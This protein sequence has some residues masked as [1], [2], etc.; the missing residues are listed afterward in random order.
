MMKNSFESNASFKILHWISVCFPDSVVPA[1]Q[2]CAQSCLTLCDPVDCTPSGSSVY[3]ILQ[4]RVL[5]WIAV[6]FSRG[7]SWP[8][9]P[10]HVS[11]TV[12]S[13]P[14]EPLTLIIWGLIVY[15]QKNTHET[16]NLVYIYMKVVCPTINLYNEVFC[17]HLFIILI[18][19]LYCLE[20]SN[21]IISI[22]NDH[23]FDLYL[24]CGICLLWAYLLLLKIMV[25]YLA[26]V[27]SRVSRN[28]NEHHA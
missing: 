6:P 14:I 1:V 3:G 11:Y 20:V 23:S 15:F 24:P 12:D 19:Q 22:R 16:M 28:W 17:L 25:S 21:L 9:D 4:A 5:E 8:K 27:G 18:Y 7:S 10:T 13:L 2:V 26:N